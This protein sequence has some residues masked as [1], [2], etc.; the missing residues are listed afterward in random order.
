MIS[1]FALAVL[2]AAAVYFMK[3]EE[4]KKLL[5]Q[6]GGKAAA[7]LRTVTHMSAAEHEFH[8]FLRARAR[9]PIATP[10]LLAVNVV[11]FVGILFGSGSMSDPQTFVA[12]GANYVPRTTH[13]EWWRLLASAFVPAG[14]F[15][16]VA[17]MAALVPLGLI[18]ERAVGRIAFASV[19]LASAIVAS[20]VSLWTAPL[21]QVTLGASGA[22]FGIYGLAISAA[23]YGCLRQPRIAV[24]LIVL[25]RIGVG[26]AV[27]LV[28]AMSTEHLGGPAELAGLGTGLLAGMMAVRT[29]AQRQPP[30]V[31]APLV[32][33]VTAIVAVALVV[34]LRGM[35]D[36]RP[37][38]ARIAAVEE[39]TSSEYAAA[40]EKFKL[41]RLP[42]KA[43]VTLIDRSVLPALARDRARVD[44]LRGAPKDQAPL[45]LAARRYFELREQSWRRRAEGLRT[46]KLPLLNEAERTER[47]ALESLAVVTP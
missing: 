26:A 42:A 28:H 47:A 2:A 44:A 8:E 27:F 20:A 19:Y 29:V 7:A 16:L 45:L 10:V 13:D 35:I 43:L 39:Q 1:L 5:Q 24:P 12:W 33:A 23:I 38:L 18:L 17:T 46:G 21:T 6:S 15:H 30:V 36:A 9:W 41:G 31:R 4:R 14:F 40:V 3:P 34:P 32:A 11:V 22:I 25:K 37:E